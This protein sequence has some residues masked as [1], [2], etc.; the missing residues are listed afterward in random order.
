MSKSSLDSTSLLPDA[1]LIEPPPVLAHGRHPLTALQALVHSR[2]NLV[3]LMTLTS[4]ILLV[5]LFSTRNSRKHDTNSELWLPKNEAKRSMSYIG[6]TAIL[7]AGAL[8][9]K[10]FFI[11]TDVNVWPDLDCFDVGVISLFYQFTLQGFTM[12]ELGLVAQGAT[13]LFMEVTNLT[14]ARLALIPGSLLTG[15]LLSPIL[16]LSR[17]IAQRPIKRIR[18]PEEKKRHRRLLALSFYVLAALITGGLIGQWTRWCLGKRNPFVWAVLW[19]LQGRKPWSRIALLAYWCLLGS[20]SVAG[21]N[22]QLA[23]VRRYRHLPSGTGVIVPG[24]LSSETVAEPPATVPA[25]LVN[26]VHVTNVNVDRLATAAT[27]FLDAADK[28]VPTLGRNARRKFFHGLAVVMMLPGVAFDPAFVHLS[29]SAAFALFVFAE[30]VRYFALYPFGAVVHLFLNEFLDHKDSGTAV[31]SHFYLLTGS[32]GPLWLEGQSRILEFTGVLSLGIGDALA[33]IVGKRIGHHRWSPGSPKTLEGSVAYTLSVV[34]CAW[35]L[36]AAS[37]VPTFSL[38][39]K[40][41]HSRLLHIKE[42]P[43]LKQLP[44]PKGQ[45]GFEVMPIDEEAPDEQ[46]KLNLSA[47]NPG[48]NRRPSTAA[49][50]QSNDV[51]LPATPQV[52]EATATL[53]SGS[54][55]GSVSPETHTVSTTLPNSTSGHTRSVSLSSSQLLAMSQPESP[56][57]QP[58]LEKVHHELNEEEC[59]WSS[60]VHAYAAGKWDPRMTPNPPKGSRSET[61][62]SEELRSSTLPQTGLHVIGNRK[63]N[64]VATSSSSITSNFSPGTTKSGS[65]KSP[66]STSTAASSCSS[67]HSTPDAGSTSESTSRGWSHMSLKS[68]RQMIQQGSGESPPHGNNSSSPFPQLTMPLPS[69]SFLS[70]SMSDS[71]TAV[72]STPCDDSV[73]TDVHH[74]FQA[75]AATMRLAGDGVDVRPLALPSPEIELTDPFRGHMTSLSRPSW[76]REGK[77]NEMDLKLLSDSSSNNQGPGH[78][79]TRLNSFWNVLGDVMGTSPS[80][81]GGGSPLANTKI[82]ERAGC[83]PNLPTISASPLVT[84]EDSEVAIAS[85]LAPTDYLSPDIPPA[86][87][88]IPGG[89]SEASGGDYFAHKGLKIAVEKPLFSSPPTVPEGVQMHAEHISAVSPVL[90][91]SVFESNPPSSSST[92][93]LRPSL[94][95]TESE[96]AVSQITP[97]SDQE[98]SPMLHA[99][100][101]IQRPYRSSKVREEFE[102]YQRGYLVPPA[103]LN[104]W[105]RQKALYKF[106]IVHTTKDANFDRIAL[107]AKLV[108]NG[109][110]CLISLIDADELWFKSEWHPFIRFYAGAPLR[111]A[112]GFNIG[113]L[114]LIDTEPRSEF[115]PRQRHTLKEFAIQLRIRD[116]IQISMEQFTREC[117]EIDTQAQKGDPHLLLSSTSMEKI[118]DRAAK[119]VKRTLDVEGAVLIDVSSFEEF[120]ALNAETE[121]LSV[122]LYHSDPKQSPQ[123]KPLTPTGFEQMAQFFKDFPDGKVSEAVLPACIRGFMPGNIH[124]ALTV[125]I[126]NIDK[127]PFAMLCAYNSNAKSRPYL[128]GHELSYLRAIGVIILSAVL[129]R[130]MILADKAKSLFIS[131]ISHEL[132]TPL[133]GILAAAELLSGTDLSPNQ[134]SFLSTVQACGTS[135][136]ETVNHVLDFTKLSGSTKAGG[137]ET[138]IRPAQVDLA[139]LIEEATEGC[140]IGHRARHSSEIGT[141]Y[142]PRNDEDGTAQN[143]PMR[144]QVETAVDIGY[145]SKGWNVVCEKGGIRR[146][147][148]NLLGNAL[149]F[150]AEGYVH[151]TLRQLPT[152]PNAPEDYIKLELGVL[153]SG[154]GISED[155][156]K[157]QLFQP[158]SQENPLQPGTGLGLAIV[159]SIV[160]SESVNGKIDVWSAEGSGTEIRIIFEVQVSPEPALSDRLGDW[161]KDGFSEPPLVSLLGF[162]QVCGQKL[163]KQ[164]ITGYL[165]EWWHFRLT[166][167]ESAIGDILIINE[168][169]DLVRQRVEQKDCYRP[170]VL[171]S[172]ARGDAYVISTV[173]D[174]ECAGGFT[175]IIYK[176]VGPSALFAVLRLCVSVLRDGLPTN[177]GPTNRSLA[178]IRESSNG[179]QYLTRDFVVGLPGSFVRRRSDGTDSQTSVLPRP[180]MPSRSITYNPHFSTEPTSMQP[181]SESQSADELTSRDNT[182]HSPNLT[183]PVGTNGLVLKASVGSV[184]VGHAIT[185]LVVEDNH[186]LRELLVKWLRTKGYAVYE[187]ADGQSGVNI[188]KSRNFDLVLLDMSMPVMDGL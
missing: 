24:A 184:A 12:G 155:F 37:I 90:Y 163:L 151:V 67:A 4:G 186:I 71:S 50:I 9:L 147:L 188:F 158:F 79:K 19:L 6:F 142:S 57:T 51:L 120:D 44:H 41:R 159:N 26:S 118:Y 72:S 84:P 164:V 145:R 81:E 127:R 20:I 100:S 14:I 34:L 22:R 75:A 122:L 52:W 105:E 175:R 126:L 66:C 121:T 154:K 162:G 103:P 130:R 119:L 113:S 171:I 133:H 178:P 161:T 107:L 73:R 42:T 176:P 58:L 137:A 74:D 38:W 85:N 60:F 17:H 169:I 33:S 150:T 82:V 65:D 55:S 31:L 2:R 117:L 45:V 27:E 152:N 148:M 102:F 77:S 64:T 69:R 68:R 172:S 153:D 59:D 179:D 23:R 136:V 165:E 177:Y 56:H 48:P 187:A 54:V 134:T 101:D 35:V 47:L 94:N 125:P 11:H 10:A 29:L 123:T 180:A 25:S 170:L 128:E 32:A 15:F 99:Q 157:N 131:N 46:R 63:R 96:F 91:P 86:P 18:Y 80:N 49:L 78:R 168:D 1:W 87:A 132:R 167:P 140:W 39:V 62:R 143:A 156:L 110:I 92:V 97:L 108:F 61:D 106:N 181:G 160:H 40:L 36:R 138:V 135:L 129:K 89:V 43:D 16:V 53:A 111:T 146:C 109:K 173:G 88:P 5:H 70:R 95:R 21:W 183:I 144:S 7:T 139:Q 93:S 76:T 13:A 98:D 28:H 115:G 116:R 3:Q 112:E 149:K 114:C 83:S 166:R 124:Y 185:V 8:M 174:Y 104:E 141:V 182:P 30:Y